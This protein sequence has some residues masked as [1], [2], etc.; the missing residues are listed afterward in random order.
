[1][2]EVSLL[3]KAELDEVTGTVTF[4]KIDSS[5]NVRAPSGLK[6]V[7]DFPEGAELPSTTDMLSQ[8][9]FQVGILINNIERNISFPEIDTFLARNLLFPGENALQLSGAIV[10]GDLF[11][12][13]EV[14]PLRT[15]TVMAPL[16][17]TIEAGSTLQFSL[18]PMP[19]NVEW[20]VR[21]VG[22]EIAAPGRISA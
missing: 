4:S 3:A 18:T 13:G 1:T 16:N 7:P 17:S 20:S 10:P 8:V 19:E 12:V 11:L 9:G 14:D 5:S 6:W 2:G 21:D 22:G 15:T